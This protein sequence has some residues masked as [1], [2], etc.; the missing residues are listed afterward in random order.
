MV[1]GHV[2][3]TTGAPTKQGTPT[4][5]ASQQVSPAPPN[6]G[7]AENCSEVKGKRSGDN[8][9]PSREIT[10]A[11]LRN[12]IYDDPGL[13]SLRSVTGHHGTGFISKLQ[14]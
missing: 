3:A 7:K 2:A 9:V 5:Q 14:Q 10:H 1:F 6:R 8:K 11:S 13:V 4:D 12:L